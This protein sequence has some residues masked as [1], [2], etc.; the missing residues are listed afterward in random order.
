MSVHWEVEIISRSEGR[1][2]SPFLPM[3]E[4]REARALMA[5]LKFSKRLVKVDMVRRV[6]EQIEKERP[7]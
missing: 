3:Q 6:E 7:H 5:Q 2:I 4:E 1:W